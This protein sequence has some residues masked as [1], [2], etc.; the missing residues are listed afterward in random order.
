MAAPRRVIDLEIGRRQLVQLQSIAQSQAGP[1]AR[2]QHTRVLLVDRDDPSHFAVGRL[3]GLHHQTM[4]RCV[5][6][7]AVQG[8]LAALNDA[9]RP[10]REPVIT[11]EACVWLAALAY[12]KAKDL[13]Y[14]HEVWSPR[15]LA[16]HARKYGTAAAHAHLRDLAQGTVC[17]IPDAEE[18]KSHKARYYSQCRNPE[19]HAKMAEVRCVYW[20]VKVLKRRQPGDAVSIINYDGEPGLQ[21]VGRSAPDLPPEPG[22]H[23]RFVRNH[24]YQRHGI[25]SLLAGIY[26]ISGKIH[27]LVTDRHCSRERTIFL[28][29]LDTTYPA[30]TAIRLILDNH[31]AHISQEIRDLLA[32]QRPGHFEL[33]FTPKHGSWLNKLAR[34]V[35]RD[36]RVAFVQE[37]KDRRSVAIDHCSRN[38]DLHTWTDMRGRAA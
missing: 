11:E 33:V 37:L 20:Q 28:E 24:E 18:V 19:I 10:G 36:I 34:L 16:Q 21:A 7:A 13:R 29:L 17:K 8:A 3:L 31:F 5:E 38:P 1:S 25:V 4:Q 23:P 2:L 9:P 14:Q 22:I 27:S 15:M 6:R 32:E 30:H 26:L 12:R 35:L